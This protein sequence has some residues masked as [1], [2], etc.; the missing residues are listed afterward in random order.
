MTKE[1]RDAA[2][3]EAGEKAFQKA[4]ER[5]PYHS[6]HDRYFF[7][8]GYNAGDQAGYAR[9]MAEWNRVVDE[10]E[11]KTIGTGEASEWVDVCDEV[12]RA[13]QTDLM[14]DVQKIIGAGD[15]YAAVQMCRYIEE[16]EKAAA[17]SFVREVEEKVS[18][19]YRA[20]TMR[21]VIEAV[22]RERFGG[23]LK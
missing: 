23:E 12:E 13:R 15:P 1:A 11:S 5:V 7:C 2:I 19:G 20:F 8:A 9:A 18:V 4:A 14:I 10:H 21:E 17:A 3:N 22:F 16:R 6:T